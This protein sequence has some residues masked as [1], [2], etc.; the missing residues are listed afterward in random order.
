M[1]I[2]AEGRKGGMLA[3]IIGTVSINLLLLF[4]LGA[5]NRPLPAATQDSVAPRVACSP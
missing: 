5:L 4:A 3:A 1:A 2:N